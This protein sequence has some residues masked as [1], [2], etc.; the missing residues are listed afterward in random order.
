MLRGAIDL[1]TN[2]CLL[3]LAEVEGRTVKTVH[4]DQIRLVRLGQGVDASG[5]LH[6]DAKERTLNALKEFAAICQEHQVDPASVNAVG[7]SALRDAQDRAAFVAQIEQ[8]TGFV[9]RV[10]PGEEEAINSYWGALSSLELGPDAVPSLLDI[11]GGSTELVWA[12]GAQRWSLNMGVVRA[13]ER[14]LPSDP[15]S[16]EELVA[17]KQEVLSQLQTLPERPQ[18]APLVAVAGTP[19]TLVAIHKKLTSY[20]GALVHGTTLTYEMLEA[21]MALLMGCSLE[22]RKQLPGLHPQ[23]ADVIISGACLLMTVMEWLGQEQ[24]LVSDRGLRYGLLL[25]PAPSGR[26]TAIEGVPG[27]GIEGNS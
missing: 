24:V 14:F 10:I 8:E 9:L 19:T 3:T 17:L 20:D 25:S 21:S 5:N 26:G 16:S 2:S 12:D 1:G 4:V 22:E 18:A 7:T 6:P 23:R 27:S 15:P 13:R 11:G